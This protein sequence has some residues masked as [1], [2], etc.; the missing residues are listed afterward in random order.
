MR[1]TA[2]PLLAEIKGEYIQYRR[3]G[4]DRAEATRRVLAQYDAELIP[5][6]EPA[7]SLV[8]IGLADAQFFRKELTSHVAKMATDSADRLLNSGLGISEG[9]LQRRKAKYT[10]APMAE[11]RV[12]NPKEPFWCPWELGDTFAY[13]LTGQEAERSGVAGCY[14][15]LRKVGSALYETKYLMPVVTVTLWR[16]ETLPVTARDYFSVPPMV[17]EGASCAELV[18]EN[19]RQW[20][21]LSMTYLGNF[22]DP[23]FMEE[24]QASVVFQPE[25]LDRQILQCIPQE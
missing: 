8:W 15:L 5:G 17:L 1:L 12:G 19:R 23:A 14:A 6:R 21:A 7:C 4:C 2:F 16:K 9:D 22:Q 24:V 3:D 13:P 18:I 11:K 25:W 10:R 20:E